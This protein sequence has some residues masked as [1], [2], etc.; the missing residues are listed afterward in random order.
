MLG[1]QPKAVFE[2]R[3]VRYVSSQSDSSSRPTR[4]SNQGRD[5][6]NAEAPHD[7][8]VKPLA[9]AAHVLQLAQACAN[10]LGDRIRKNVIG[11]RV[12]LVAD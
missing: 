9:D 8:R 10:Q 12:V 6:V 4:P 3:V 2:R 7:F 11:Y 1:R 5:R